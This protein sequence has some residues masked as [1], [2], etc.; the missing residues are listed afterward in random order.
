MTSTKRFQIRKLLPISIISLILVLILFWLL[1]A[2]SAV[3]IYAAGPSALPNEGEDHSD[4]IK[5][6]VK[7]NDNHDRA[8]IYQQANVPVYGPAVNLLEDVDGST[9]ELL[10]AY[11][12][13]SN[14]LENRFESF[15]IIKEGDT[16]YLWLGSLRREGSD[17]NVYSI[18]Q[19]FESQDGL[20][21]SNRT[22]TNLS[23][24][25]TFF[26][27]IHGLREVIKTGNSYEAWEQYYYEYSS[28]WSES[29]RYVTSNDGINWAIVNQPA[30]IGAKRQS[31]IKHGNT[32]RMWANPDGDYQYTGSQSLRYRTSA[33]GGTGWGNWQS[34]GTLVT[35][36]GSKEVRGPNR[37]RRLP[38]N[39]YQLFYMEYP[40]ISLATSSDGISFTTQTANMLNIQ[41]VL[42]LSGTNGVMVDF[43][44]ID[45]DGEDWFYFTYC[46]ER[47]T[48][49]PGRC[50]DTRIAVS[51]PIKPSDLT[52]TKSVTPA[53]V[54][55][56]DLLTYTL[57][58]SNAGSTTTA[59][60][61]IITDILPISFTPSG[62]SSGGAVIT[63]TGASPAF[64]WDVQDL[65]PGQGGAITIVGQVDAEL[66][67][68]TVFTN[69][70]SIAGTGLDV[71]TGNNTANAVTLVDIPPI[72]SDL[73]ITKSVTP[74]TVTP[75]GLLTYTLTFRN[76]SAATTAKGV[77]ITDI[78][79]SS[80]TP[81][82]VNSGDAVIT[83]TGTNPAFVWDVQNLAPGQ[84]GIIT[85]VGQV[86]PNLSDSTVFT[87]TAIITGTSLDADAGNN[88]ASAAVL[89]DI[90]PQQLSSISHLP[91]ILKN[92]ILAPDLIVSNLIATSNSITITIRNIGN[93]PATDSFWVDVYIDPDP[94]PS[95]VNQ[96]WWELAAQGLVWGVTT[97][98][99]INDTLT[100]TI[101]D[102][103][104]S[105]A[106]SGFSRTLPVGTPVYVQVDSVNLN[107]NYGGV[108]ELDE[109]LTNRPYNNI[110]GTLSIPNLTNP[111][112][113]VTGSTRP[114]DSSKNLPTR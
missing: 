50:I 58:F 41:E 97:P 88:T 99:G 74:V 108:L 92:N 69:T 22:D 17:A 33:N 21:W 95:E 40:Y 37:V 12:G 67:D 70:A 84:S 83:D 34:G 3:N 7:N 85:I 2:G 18:E 94:A 90:P 72:L 96:H 14:L 81:S 113:L 110:T 30:L 25:D 46:P 8:A 61:V 79:P 82:T 5:Q 16:Y 77:I 13:L 11:A 78:M 10:S 104:Y 9:I 75:G 91:L 42:P 87:N 23:R 35:L 111:T 20:V 101:D 6:T 64:V 80:F 36:D 15:D 66:S 45:V 114:P 103:Y 57:T 53:T 106:Y 55:P 47:Y 63:D 112:V 19:R 29:I 86:D 105:A 43:N 54:M 107:T 24:H 98:I 68:G 71:N 93:A 100:L 44:V 39:T 51:R 60:N 76:G 109:I 26:A 4:Q 1:V 65:G 56:G 28:G 31:V 49:G 73:I 38:D 89:V 59:T 32:Y 102:P 62:I 48:T 27:Y 52:I